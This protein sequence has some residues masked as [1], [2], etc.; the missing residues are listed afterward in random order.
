M[1]LSLIAPLELLGYTLP[2]KLWP[3]ISEGRMFAYWLRNKGIEP[4][5]LATYIH[6]FEDGRRSVRA[7]AYPESLLA[8]FR[9]HMRDVWMP[10]R[11][12]NYFK[13]RDPMA[14]QYLPKLLPAPEK[15][16][17]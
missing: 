5:D 1:T 11:A 15:K 7:K 17:S 10:K 6:E 3:D 2:E 14:L 13:E 4:N 12:I 9:A 16:A 8:D